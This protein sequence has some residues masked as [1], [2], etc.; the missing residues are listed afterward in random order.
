VVRT[1]MPPAAEESTIRAALRKIDPGVLLLEPSTMEAIIGNSP[2]VFLRRYPSLLIGSFAALAV[3]L[4]AI[5]LYGLLAY[6]VAQQTNEIGI[7]LALGAEPKDLVRMVVGRGAKL[8]LIG[9]GVGIG[10]ALALTR[11][12]GSLLYGV[13]AADP[14]TFLAAAV[15]LTLVA[16]AACYIPARRATRIDPTMALRYE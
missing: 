4:A 6:S 15:L 8:A 10:A 7:R 16:L 11:L 3:L 1:A 9:V 2:A 5:G 14:A 13:S 12:L